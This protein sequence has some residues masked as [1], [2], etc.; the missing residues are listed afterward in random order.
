M[1]RLPILLSLALLAGAALASR[2]LVAAIPGDDESHDVDSAL[3]EGMNQLNRS[4]RTL[5]KS[6][7]DESRDAE[8]LL[9]VAEAERGAS[10]CKT[11]TP[12]LT[13]QQPEAE[14]AAYVAEFRRAL[15][16]V[17]RGLLDVEEALLAGDREGAQARLKAVKKL[18]GPG[19]DRFAPEEE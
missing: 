16:E 6:L 2:P 5:R 4:L 9:V 3:H 11:E 10:R 18:E 14:R 1:R 8:S 7:R 15:I 17:Q 12:P 13:A 19:H